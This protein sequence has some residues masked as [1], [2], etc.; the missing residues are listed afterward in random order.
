MARPTS[1]HH[2]VILH[3]TPTAMAMRLSLQI[4]PIFPP[5][6]PGCPWVAALLLVALVL[7]LSAAGRSVEGVVQGL[8][9]T[10]DTALA[11]AFAEAD[12]P[13]PPRRIALLGFKLERRLELWAQGPFEDAWHYVKTYRVRAASGYPGPKLRQGDRQ[14]PEGLYQVTVLNPNSRFHLSMGLSYP[15]AFDKAMARRDGRTGL[16]GDIFIHG[17][18]VSTGCLALGDP[19]IE[20]LFVLVHQ[21]GLD[22]VE[23]LIAPQ[24][25]R[26][27]PHPS[28]AV[29]APPWL[30]DLYR[31]LSQALE[32][33]PLPLQRLSR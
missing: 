1:I 2:N 18:Q 24:D 8:Q 13:Y 31:Q 14:V 27:R 4:A 17:D 23:V 5:S 10:V 25:L 12:L 22:A 33:F 19:A 32:R 11:P 15:N 16:G 28:M 26:W 7:P 29:D 9:G 6:C 30:P 20:E 21:V 3:G